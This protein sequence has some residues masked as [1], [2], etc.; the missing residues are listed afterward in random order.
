M[1][2]FAYKARAANGE[3]VQGVLEGGDSSAIAT[4][5]FNSGVTP[6]EISPSR[7]A[8]PDSAGQVLKGLFKPRVTAA[9]ILLF[10]RQMYTLLKAGVPIMRAL[11]GLQES[12][13][14]ERF[15]E[16]LRSVRENLDGGREVSIALQRQNGVFNHFYVNMIKVGEMTGQLEEIFLRL[17]HHLEFESFMRE[18]VR[19]ALRYPAF[20]IAAMAIAMVIINLF[21]IPVFAK[22]FAS[23]HATLPVMTQWLIGFSS[24]TV[25]YWSVILLGLIIA[26]ALFRSWIGTRDGRYTWDRVKLRLPIAGKIIVKATLARFA[27]S[28]ALA[29]RS[30]VPVVQALST[31]ALTVDNAYVADK[32]EKMRESVERGE[33]VLRSAAA[34]GIF[35]PVV[36][37]MIAVGEESGAIDDLMEEIADMYQREVELELKTLSAQ[38][39]PILIIGLGIMV[40]ILA[41]GVFLPMWELGNA[42]IK[43]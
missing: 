14:N 12:T 33:S 35:T 29:A 28:F 27:R 24:F 41:L 4:Q 26:V 9:D 5:L 13:V 43:R 7:S 34:S 10:S 6:V 11:A 18:Q 22:V 2:H 37:Q 25:E 15:K 23:F 39:E 16:V 40:L 32:I 38:I 30:G 17:F 3:L 36:L 8:T 21:V 1:P 42:A 19:S 20:V 31:V